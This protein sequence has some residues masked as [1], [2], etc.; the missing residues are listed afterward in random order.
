MNVIH[1]IKCNTLLF[2]AQ[3]ARR[4]AK[5]GM[6]APQLIQLEEEID[7]EI[8]GE[9]PPEPAAQ[10]VTC[11]LMSL[12]EMVSKEEDKSPQPTQ[13]IK[14]PLKRRKIDLMSLDEMV[15]SVRCIHRSVLQHGW[16]G[17]TMHRSSEYHGPEKGSVPSM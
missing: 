7:A 8:A 12:D 11:D 16:F 10:R 13:E 2:R 17:G 3:V 4:G 9:E 6:L 5:Y 15:R 14:Q 1:Y